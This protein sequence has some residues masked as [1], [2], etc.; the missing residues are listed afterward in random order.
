MPITAVI[1]DVHGCIRT[2]DKLINEIEKRNSDVTYLSLGD[3]I[4]RGPG[5]CDVMRLFKGLQD[6]G[7]LEFIRGNHEDVLIDFVEETNDYDY[8]NWLMYGGRAT[9]S[10]ISGQECYQ[11]VNKIDIKDYKPYIDPYYEFLS[12][13]EFKIGKEYK[14]NKFMFSHAGIGPSKGLAHMVYE[15]QM[16][17]NYLFMWSRDTWRST[18]Q[19]FGYTM[20]H[21]H[22][23]TKEIEV[24]DDPHKPFVNKNKNGEL[25]SVAIDTGCVYGYSLSA[26]LIDEYGDFDFISERNV[27]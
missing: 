3:I 10:C 11:P 2:L 17:E 6:E 9:L 26:M 4:D 25:V 5:I 12:S 22:T 23:P 21:G 20:V 24:H 16:R 19:Y 18:E 27:D 13:A 1:G 7:R 14:N 15:F 8:S